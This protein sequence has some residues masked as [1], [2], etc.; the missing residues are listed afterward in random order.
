MFAPKWFVIGFALVAVAI[1]ASYDLRFGAAASALLLVAAAIWLALTI[2]LAPERDQPLSEREAMFKRFAR[3]ARN[4][5]EAKL[6]ELG[7]ERGPEA[8]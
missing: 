1:I 2:W 3:L 4:R 8:S 5:R 6:K 7:A